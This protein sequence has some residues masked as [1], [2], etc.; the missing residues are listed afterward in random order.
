MGHN[1]EKILRLEVSVNNAHIT[2]AMRKTLQTFV[3]ITSENSSSEIGKNTIYE[4]QDFAVW[5]FSQGIVTGGALH[6]W[7]IWTKFVRTLELIPEAEFLDLLGTKVLRVFLLAIH[8]H[9]Y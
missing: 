3:P 5:N 9:L 1:F 6:T 8:S 7:K 2:I 4:R